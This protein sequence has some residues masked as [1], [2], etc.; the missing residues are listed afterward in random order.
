MLNS[1]R[2]SANVASPCADERNELQ[3]CY[4]PEFMPSDS[5]DDHADQVT[6]VPNLP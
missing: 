5:E 3:C 6:A 2:C 4:L 1:A